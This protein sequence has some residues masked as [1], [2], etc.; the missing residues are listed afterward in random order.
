[1]IFKANGA[2]KYG[3]G[4]LE[5]VIQTKVLP[6]DLSFRLKW[7]RFYNSY[8]QPDTNIPL[9]L[10]VSACSYSELAVTEAIYADYHL[11]AGQHSTTSKLS[12]SVFQ[13]CFLNVSER[14]TPN[15][16]QYYNHLDKSMRIDK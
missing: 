8:N 12:H 13:S 7:N 15:I 1:M 2:H 5:T 9:D 10:Q 4:I 11:S 14:A 3:C 16:T 6:E